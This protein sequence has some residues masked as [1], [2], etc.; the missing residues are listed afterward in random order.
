MQIA[1]A[2]LSTLRQKVPR[3]D[4]QYIMLHRVHPITHKG[5][6][7]VAHT[8]FKGFSGRGWGMYPV[9]FCRRARRFSYPQAESSYPVEPADDVVKPIKLSRTKIN[10][11]LGAGVKTHL[12]Q[13]Q[14]DKTTHRGI[15]SELI[16]I[17]TP[18]IKT[19]ED[20]DGA[21]SEVVVPDEFPP[22]SILLFETDM[23]VSCFE[24]WLSALEPL[25][26][27]D[28]RSPGIWTRSA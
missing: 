15:P 12:D 19:G 23:Q 11:I 5:Y 24:L 25:V 3:T 9:P 28:R 6:M 7:L 20:A 17:A 1:S 22:G 13:W 18:E 16:E 8:A 10:F 21:F 2:R 26:D 14:D 4:I 27:I